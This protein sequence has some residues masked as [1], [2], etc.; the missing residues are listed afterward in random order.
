MKYKISYLPCE[1]KGQKI[2][3]VLYLPETNEKVPLAIYA[4]GCGSTLENCCYFLNIH[5][6]RSNSHVFI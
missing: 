6:N 2:Y 5:R 3:G 1:N 4:H